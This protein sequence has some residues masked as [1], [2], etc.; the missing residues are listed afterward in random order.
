VIQFDTDP[1]IFVPEKTTFREDHLEIARLHRRSIVR[2]AAL[3][4]GI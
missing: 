3:L 4:N 2:S 1:P